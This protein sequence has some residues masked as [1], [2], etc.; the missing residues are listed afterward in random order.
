M[1]EVRAIGRSTPCRGPY[2]QRHIELD[3]DEHGP[4]ALRLLDVLCDGD[5]DRIA[6][7]EEVGVEAIEASSRLWDGVLK[8]IHEH[9]AVQVA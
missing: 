5:P 3:H 6:R 7:A 2:L 1:G 9:R 8:E 4:L